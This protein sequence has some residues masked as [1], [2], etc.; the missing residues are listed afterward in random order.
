MEQEVKVRRQVSEVLSAYEIPVEIIE[1]SVDS[2]LAERAQDPVVRVSE[3]TTGGSADFIYMY[4]PGIVTMYVL[5]SLTLS[6]RAIVEERK[7]GT[8]ERC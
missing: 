4:L 2:V 8:L 5:F 1:S 3:T 6:A 7:R